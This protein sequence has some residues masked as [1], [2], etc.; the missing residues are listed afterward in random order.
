MTGAFIELDL[1]G[2]R[3]DEAQRLIDETL[4][5]SD[6]SV[7]RL[8]IIHG[9]HRGTAIRDMILTEYRWHERVVRIEAGD[10]RGQTDLI[11]REF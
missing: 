1:H 8:R 7:Y 10:N 4:Q 2:A 3:T 5:N 9:F 11:L 6:A